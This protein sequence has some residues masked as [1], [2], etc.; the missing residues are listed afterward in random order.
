M[1]NAIATILATL[2]LAAL[3]TAVHALPAAAGVIDF[4]D[5]CTVALL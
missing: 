1:R 4:R 3:P 5:H 2:L